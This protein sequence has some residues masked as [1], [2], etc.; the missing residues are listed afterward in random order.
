MTPAR[1]LKNILGAS[2]GNFVEWFDWFAYASFA[3]Y[4]SRAFFPAGDQTAQL[5]NTAFI[6]AGGFIARPIGALLFG[7]Y[8]DRVGRRAALTLSVSMMCGGSLLIAVAPTGMGVLS[9][10]LL[11]VAR[12]V[13]GLAVGG[14]YGASATYVSEMASSRHRGFWSGFL[15]VTL[16]GGQLAAMS[17]QVLLQRVLSDEQLYAWGWRIPFVIGA[18][19]AV[20]VFWIRRGIE[21]TASFTA[22][23]VALSERGRPL[24]LLTEYGRETAIVLALTAAGAIGFYTYAVY[25]QK[26]LVNSAGFDKAVAAEIMT[27]V[28]AT[29]VFFP[30]LLGWIADHVGRRR[31][32][33]VS[34]GAS[35]LL[36]VPML[37]ALAH[38]DAGRPWA[39][40]LLCLVPLFFLSGYY[41]LSAIIKAEL[42]PVHVRALGVS[43]PY[44]VALAIFGGNAE[45]AA[46]YFKKAGMEGGYYWL[47]AAVFTIGFLA[48]TQL[49][50][51]RSG[52]RLAD[53]GPALS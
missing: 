15:Y 18:L 51:E 41:A 47:V 11:V 39:V 20:V 7:R 49:P 23:E 22:T 4:F 45:T 34:F 37:N 8:G 16:I 19:L 30:P 46:L 43:L 33:L 52:T 10:L 3:L 35:A 24:A 36:A 40:Y 50:D 14:E 27:A 25:M 44:A 32:L 29:L 38:A 12:L 9:P 28:L 6:F 13:Q 31:T 2:A 26:L 53:D 5:L 17:L 21:E 1:R 48:A 42:Y